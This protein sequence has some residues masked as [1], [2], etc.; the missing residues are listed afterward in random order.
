MR[1]N[2]YQRT[3]ILVC[4]PGD[5][6]RRLSRIILENHDVRIVEEPNEGLVM[7]RMRETA[8]NSLFHLG[9][10]L[11][12]EAKV[13][14]G[15]SIGIGILQGQDSQKAF[16][17]AVIDAA[18]SASLPECLAWDDELAAAE[19][20]LEEKLKRETAQVNKTRV[21]FDTMDV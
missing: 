10:V 17:L 4:S 2:R 20:A 12:T 8:R 19:A 9:E 5:V 15:T 6:A 18:W 14:I 7:I 16:D 11:V 21:Q 13:R 1:Y 3:R